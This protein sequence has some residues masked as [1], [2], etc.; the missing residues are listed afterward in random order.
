MGFAG[1][2]FFLS[3]LLVALV[4]HISRRKSWYDRLDER[5][6]HFGNVPRL[7]G[8]GFSLAFIIVSVVISLA[9]PEEG[10]GLRFLPVVAGMIIV[11]CIGVMDDFSPL[12]PRIK[13][14]FQFIAALL[15]AVPGYTF[16]RF[17]FFDIGGFGELAPWIS[18]PVTVLWLVGMTN[19]VNF[20]DGVDGLSG[21]IS[22]LSAAT[23]GFISLVLSDN[24]GVPLLS[25]SLAAALAGFLVFNLPLPGAKIF[26][27]DGGALFLGFTL[28]LLPL[29]DRGGDMLTLPLPYAAAL[30]FIPILDV[31]AA[32]WRRLRDG[33]PVDRPDRGHVHHKL[34]NLGLDAKKIDAV[35][36]SLQ[37]MMGALV[38]IAVKTPGPRSV[39]IL[40]AAYLSGVAFFSA[41][42]FMNRAAAARKKA[43]RGNRND[44]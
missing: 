38:Y 40:A 27:G 23:F 41:V 9:V 7:G 36:W 10:Y 12:P 16:H 43:A 42:H 14:V 44:A 30:L 1:L 29:A 25:F 15:V 35:L 17:F 31:T 22:L 6:I 21:G 18:Y 19:A 24:G 3:V 11:L 8:V 4:L 33:H 5:K 20:I 28:A 37:I 32:V 34:M 26:M 2:S 39:A 13:L